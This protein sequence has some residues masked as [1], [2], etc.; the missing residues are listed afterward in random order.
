VIKS[1]KSD[2]GSA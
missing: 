2:K 1:D